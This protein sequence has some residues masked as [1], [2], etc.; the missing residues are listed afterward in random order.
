LPYGMRRNQKMPAEKGQLFTQSFAVT[1]MKRERLTGHP[2]FTIWLTGLSGSGK[3]SLASELELWLHKNNF[4]SYIIDGDN[5]RLG[6]NRDLDFS[7]EGRD[8][9]IRRVA[10]I[11]KLMN[12]AG[13]IVICSF[14]SPYKKGRKEAAQIIGENNFTEVFINATIETCMHRDTKGLYKLAAGGKIKD[15]T[16]VNSPYEVPQDPSLIISTDHVPL[17]KSAREI[18]DWVK[19]NK[20][21]LTYAKPATVKE[22]VLQ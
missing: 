19:K 2:S 4:H 12:E 10:E 20:L 22:S 6:I 1:K 18:I 11:C 21:P 5:T 17:Q 16:G 15:F 8:E 3:S 9:N 13:I 14:I 7:K